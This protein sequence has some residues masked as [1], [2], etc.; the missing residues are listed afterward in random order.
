M[1]QDDIIFPNFIQDF[2]TNVFNKKIPCIKST[3][4]ESYTEHA[5]FIQNFGQLWIYDAHGRSEGDGV[6]SFFL[7]YFLCFSYFHVKFTITFEH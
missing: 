6:N 5:Q 2:F 3:A 1:Q 7:Q 4:T